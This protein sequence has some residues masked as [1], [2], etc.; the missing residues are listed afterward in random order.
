MNI[1]NQFRSPFIAKKC[2]HLNNIQSW[3]LISRH[4][5]NVAE[6]C[7]SANVPK[8][9]IFGLLVRTGTINDFPY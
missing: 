1:S 2:K 8:V 6:N 3:T 5:R 7:F 9:L 4:F